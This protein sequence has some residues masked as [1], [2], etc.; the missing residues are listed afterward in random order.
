VLA[1]LVVEAIHSIRA[2]NFTHAT[3]NALSGRGLTA[4]TGLLIGLLRSVP[5]PRIA[6]SKRT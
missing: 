2:A 4:G 5:V 3:W 1:V 6:S